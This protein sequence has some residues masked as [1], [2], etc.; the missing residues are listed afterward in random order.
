MRNQ[1]L[2]SVAVAAL[3]LG[4][5]PAFAQVN[6]YPDYPDY[7]DIRDPR[8]PAKPDGTSPQLHEGGQY[9]NWS[10][11]HQSG[12]G[13]YG[14]GGYGNEA[15]VDQEGG[16]AGSAYISQHGDDHDAEINQSDYAT[17]SPGYDLNRAA[18]YQTYSDGA[19]ALIN[20]NHDGYD[21]GSPNL[22]LISQYRSPDAMAE[23]Y[24][25]G[26]GNDAVIDQDYSGRSGGYQARSLIHQTGYR[27]WASNWQYASSGAWSEISQEGEHNQADVTQLYSNRA[28]SWVEQYGYENTAL[29]NQEHSPDASST[30][31]Q[32]GEANMAEVDQYYSR[33]A[34]SWIYQDGYQNMAVVEQYYAPYSVS[35][36]LQYGAY[37][38]TQVS[39]TYGTH[40]SF[41]SQYGHG[42]TAFVTQ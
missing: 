23:I 41:V 36:V 31:L 4:A 30:V 19:S 39:Q 42:N 26:S 10:A 16:N 21:S 3:T 29:V 40:S 14:Y 18:I 35:T 32:Y 13:Y 28:R 37:N 20:Q 22:A 34:D 15:D 17:S 24:Q 5:V 6:H 33:D 8:D 12:D 38:E 1:L 9:D 25:D 27:N 7:P 2:A 11:I